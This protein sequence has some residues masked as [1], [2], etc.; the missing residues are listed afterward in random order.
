MHNVVNYFW[1]SLERVEERVRD[2]VPVNACDPDVMHGKLGNGSNPR[3]TLDI[4][5]AK[6]FVAMDLLHFRHQSPAV[7]LFCGSSN[8]LDQE[9]GVVIFSFD[10]L[11]IDQL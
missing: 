7:Q 11:A 10:L 5:A 8:D 4:H 6:A 9:Q 2:G 3:I 1:G